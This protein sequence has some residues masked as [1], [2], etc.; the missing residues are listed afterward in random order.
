M[1]K[2]KFKVALIIIKKKIINIVLIVERL[3]KINIK[4]VYIIIRVLNFLK[5][6]KKNIK[7]NKILI[8]IF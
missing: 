6:L 7:V 5:A 4:H 2:E 8:I 3:D 1:L